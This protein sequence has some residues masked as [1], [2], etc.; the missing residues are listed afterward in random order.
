MDVQQKDTI[1]FEV[2]DAGS[3]EFSNVPELLSWL[4]GELKFWEWAQKNFAQDLALLNQEVKDR[5]L[6][7]LRN[8]IA[9][10]QRLTQNPTDGEALSQGPTHLS[11]YLQSGLVSTTARS[12]FIEGIKKTQGELFAQ[13]A[14]AAY[15][16]ETTLKNNG[17]QPQQHRYKTQRARLHML[18][19]DDG[20][21][22]ESAEHSK[23]SIRSI[24]DQS[25]QL[26]KKN[27]DAVER[28]IK[29]ADKMATDLEES[30]THTLGEHSEAHSKALALFEERG[31]KAVESIKSTEAHFTTRMELAAP[32]D[33]W[34]EKANI[35]VTNE[36]AWGQRLF[37]YSLTA[38][39]LTIAVYVGC[40]TLAWLNIGTVKAEALPI[41]VLASAALA[42]F[43]TIVFWIARFLVR[44]FLSERHMA[45]DAKARAVMTKTF[46]ALAKNENVAREDRAI[47]L[48]PLFRSANDGIIQDDTGFDSAISMLARALEKK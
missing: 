3:I 20:M 21:T 28:R 16:G 15:L 41:F 48:Q 35:H 33:Y 34:N 17:S 42:V 8:A 23:A 1:R 2:L 31:T 45:I 36:R 25:S 44:L 32:V 37:W 24:C 19:F 43:T 11:A 7:S 13:A 26:L 5:I 39:P 12:Q 30:H 9:F 18:L 46:L 38:A 6:N 4:Q 10:Y 40:F 47:V 22:K 29:R 27:A 14:L